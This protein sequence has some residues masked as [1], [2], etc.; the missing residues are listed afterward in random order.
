MPSKEG[1]L[2]MS[3]STL[4]SIIQPN[5]ALIMAKTGDMIERVVSMLV[6]KETA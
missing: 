6:M 3:N 4:S 1:S 5:N 2:K